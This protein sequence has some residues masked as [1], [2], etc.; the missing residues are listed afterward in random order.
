MKE[1]QF[2]LKAALYTILLY[3]LPK[4]HSSCNCLLPKTVWKI[5]W[6][7]YILVSFLRISVTKFTLRSLVL[8]LAETTW[9]NLER[10]EM[11][12]S[13]SSQV[14]EDTSWKQ[15]LAV[16]FHLFE[17]YMG[18]Y[19]IISA[20]KDEKEIENTIV[21]VSKTTT[22]IKTMWVFPLPPAQCVNWLF[23]C[24]WHKI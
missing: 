23:H 21:E 2:Y 22:K 5:Y 13:T 6:K 14:I 8:R 9:T 11:G 18:Q 3:K 20:S 17:K 10:L 4:N 24:S 19:W 1:L 15:K 12:T 16:G 7:V